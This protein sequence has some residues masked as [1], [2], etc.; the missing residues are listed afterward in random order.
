MPRILHLS[1]FQCTSSSFT[2]NHLYNNIILVES[3]TILGSIHVVDFF[4]DHCL[5][6]IIIHA[7]MLHVSL[8]IL[9]FLLPTSHVFMH[10]CT[11]TDYDCV[12]HVNPYITNRGLAMVFNPTSHAIAKNISLPLYY[13]GISNKALVMQ[14]GSAGTTYDLARDYTISLPIKM[15]PMT[16]TWYLIHSA[17]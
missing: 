8:Y 5:C 14:E 16:I 9:L 13:T 3:S 1:A 15:D 12:L 17:D 11:Y 4:S 10:V 2:G 6:T 7:P